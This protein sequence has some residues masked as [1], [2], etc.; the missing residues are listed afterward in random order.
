MGPAV[1]E[2]AYRECASV[3]FD[4]EC[5]L[6]IGLRRGLPDRELARQRLAGDV[7]LMHPRRVEQ[8]GIPRQRE[9]DARAHRK[10]GI[11]PEPLDATHQL[12]GAPFLG[13][14]LYTSDAADERSSVALG[15]RRIITKTKHTLPLTQYN[16]R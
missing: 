9:R 4:F 12:A 8:C 13:C 7:L 2:L 3:S 1:P 11:L 14:L 10:A 6:P 15:G 5:L 16:I